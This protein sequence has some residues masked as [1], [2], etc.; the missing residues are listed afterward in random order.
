MAK[1]KI[2]E[3]STVDTGYP[4]GYGGVGGKPSAIT[5]GVKTIDVQ[6]H[7]AA[8]ASVSNGYI[9][10]QKGAKKF[11]CANSA[12]GDD[13]TDLTSV[14]LVN[15]V[16]GALDAGEASIICY[17]TSNTAFKASRITNKFVY[18]FSGNKYIY[19]VDTVATAT[20]ANVAVA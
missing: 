10:A 19:K 15:K 4:S 14:V 5:S 16:A 1:L 7:T 13:S 18:D 3:S 8:N 11:L 17:D 9:V 12:V 2:A 6:Y 20:Y